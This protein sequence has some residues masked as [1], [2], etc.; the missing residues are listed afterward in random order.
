LEDEGASQLTRAGRRRFPG[1]VADD[2]GDVPGPESLQPDPQLA[3]F[4]E[5]TPQGEFATV[6]RGYDRYSVTEHI[7][8][9]EAEVRQHREQAQAMR[10][11]LAEAHRQIRLQGPPAYSGLGDRIEQLLRPAEEQAIELVQAAWSDA[12]KIKAAA[13]VDA[14]EFRAAAEHEASQL[15]SNAL[16]ETDDQRGA[17][18][19]DADSIRAA[20]RRKA[21]ELT[22]STERD[23]A[24]LRATADHE[25][26]EKRAAAERD[27]A[28]LRT[29]TEREVA[30]LKATAKRERDEIL[31]TSKRQADEMR[32]QAQR[33]LAESEPQRARAETELYIQLAARREEAQRQEA[34][35]LSAAQ[36]AAHKLVSEAEQRAST[37][38][39]WAAKASAQADQTRRDAAS[40]GRQLVSNAKKNADQIIS[41]AKS[42]AEQ[43]LAETKAD[44]ERRRAAAQREVDELIRQ[45]DSIASNLAQLRQS[46]GQPPMDA[47]MQPA[48]P[49]A[50]STADP[51][52]SAPPALSSALCDGTSAPPAPTTVQPA[53]S[54]PSAAH[55]A[56]QV[57]PAPAQAEGQHAAAQRGH[58]S[59]VGTMLRGF[60]VLSAATVLIRL[61]GFVVITLF[62]RRAGPLTFGT[63][64]FA[65]ALAGFVVGAPTNFGIGTLGIRNIARD[66]ADAGKV[67]GEAL[68]VQ[69]IIAA[70]AVALLVA[71]VP[72]LSTNEEL[73]TLTPIVALYYVAY[74]MTVDWALQGLQRLRAVAAARLA[75]QVLFGIVT[76][77]ILIRGPTG[78]E[79]YAAVLAAGAILTAIAAFAMVRRAVGPIRV[80]WAIAPLWDLAKGAAPLG[81]SLVMLQV[82]Y[83]MDQVLLGLL[84]N[85]A[86]VGQYAAAAKLP[87][88]LSGFTAI[89][90]S[91]VYPHASKLF[92]HDPDALRRQLGS[93]TSLS[94]VAALPLIAG[95]AI[96]G[97]GVMTG[98]FGPAY[99]PAGTPFAILMGASAVVVVATNY[100][101]LAMAAGQERTFAMSVTIASI[102]N[103]LLNLLL[104]PFYGATGAAIS[105][106]AAESVVFLI[107]A[108][109]VA[110]VIGRPPL[111]GR[112][113]AGAVAATALMSA[114]LIAMPSSISV[115]LRIAAG[116]AVYLAAAAACGAVRWE[117]L[118]LLRRGV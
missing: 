44:A 107:C 80:S 112:R 57:R 101:S 61:I 18:E 1:G 76:P 79:R 46:L 92:T 21:D 96:V 62:A 103:V 116:G 20:A 24:K 67:V 82:Y 15:R 25:V 72:L 37:A 97:T 30:Q 83:S 38:E 55:Q 35:R 91:A 102:I 100:T 6:V 33:K 109:R 71:L 12:N 19:R 60:A 47:A 87:V 63:Y 69:A 77:L 16:R 27:L 34:K 75:G 11:E 14:A 104:I 13:K 113:I 73:V 88:V 95:S 85:K 39:Q 48:A 52:P 40:R 41:Q 8:H 5:E 99:G 111:A 90:L 4:F 115:W 89:W 50:A 114:A 66:P 23:L 98:L 49:K 29:S 9:V 58:L 118:A 45:K 43:M 84:T 42:E 2:S 17:A 7:R 64:S 65:L 110:A 74:S 22:S 86:E 108:R 94:V 70:I 26:A 51:A 81:F 31:T 36:S 3:D 54:G 10:R 93:F 56:A 68:A 53:Q 105:T 59:G 117:D 28:N 78:A 106:V 32:S